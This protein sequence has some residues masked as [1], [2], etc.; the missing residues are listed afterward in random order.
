[1]SLQMKFPLQG[2]AE[3]AGAVQPV[4]EKALGGDLGAAF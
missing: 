1:V 3:K 4:E 2:Q